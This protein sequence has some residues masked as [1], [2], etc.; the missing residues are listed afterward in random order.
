MSPELERAVRACIFPGFV[1]LEVPG[2]LQRWLDDGLGGVCLFSRNVRE[3]EQLTALAAGLRA[4]R[5][6]VLVGIDEEGGDV[7]R[8]ELSTGSSYPGAW[9]L[10][11]VD[12]VE[13]T[14]RVGA[15]IGSDLA[16]VGVNLNLAPVADVNTNPD[17]PVIGIRSFG[18]DAA[19]VSR[20]VAAFVRGLQGVGVAACAKHFPGHGDTQQDSHLELP[21]VEPDAAAFEAALQP[22][23]AAIDAGA[24]AIMTAHIRVPALDDA[25][26]TLSRAL[27]DGV[28]RGELGF[29]G[30]IVTDA[31]EM[32]GV[33]AAYGLAG[34]AV[35]ALAAGADA[36]LLGSAID[37]SH[38]VAV[39][40]AIVSAVRDGVLAE[41]RVLDAAA[42]VRELG[43]WAAAPTPAEPDRAVGAEAAARALVVEG[44]VLVGDA[45]L[46]VA[47]EPRPGI[48]SGP[49]EHGLA[50][51][52]RERLPEVEAVS[53]SAWPTGLD[54]NP[55]DRRL[56]VVTKDLARHAWQRDALAALLAAAPD[57]VVVETGI[58]SG[59]PAGSAGFVATHGAGRVN[60]E[61]A[62]TALTAGARVGSRARHATPGSPST[63]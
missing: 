24:R 22:F 32:R 23:R 60:L 45:P 50:S 56:V 4:G 53:L 55:G 49:A 13:L 28:L 30:A 9:A 40:G 15:A 11:A 6:D 59:R 31:L 12:D 63:R 1:G 18:S 54:V 48:A 26:A 39:H 2:W 52:L 41:E 47:L 8:L 35:R 29:E 25:P 19:R 17:N 33:S 7:T 61:A 20:H 51:L 58:P 34:A 27:L 37:E 3:P 57:A 62:T 46:V 42:R 44:D 14:E 36:L 10:G 16:R 21:T 43:R 38:V 5:D